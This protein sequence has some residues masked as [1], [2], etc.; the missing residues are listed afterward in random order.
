[1]LGQ[2]I[3]EK[4]QEQNMSQVELAEILGI[5]NAY[6]SQIETGKYR[7]IPKPDKASKIAQYLEIELWDVYQMLYSQHDLIPA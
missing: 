2:L 3:K 4:R 7:R 1:M 6:L 5:S